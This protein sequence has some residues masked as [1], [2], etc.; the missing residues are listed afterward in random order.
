MTS[1]PPKLSYWHVWADDQGVTHQTRCDLTAFTLSSVGGKAAPQWNDHLLTGKTN[2]QFTVL[3][4][5]WIGDWHRNPEPQWIAV[6][7]GRW[8]VE[9]TDGMRTE[10]RAGDVSFG[11]DQHAKVDAQGRVGHRSGTLGNEPCALMIVQLNSEN[12]VGARP[13]SFK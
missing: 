2:I 6:L 4:V 12:W 3:P 11:G 1:E 8:F 9:T 10:M 5:G 13:G 7:S